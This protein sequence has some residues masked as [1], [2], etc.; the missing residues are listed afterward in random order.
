MTSLLSSV[1][2]TQSVNQQ[3]KEVISMPL[4]KEF[5]KTELTDVLVTLNTLLRDKL[6]TSSEYVEL[7]H[8]FFEVNRKDKNA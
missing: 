1:E 8:T 7:L 5:Q 3:R 4:T 6:I 2:N